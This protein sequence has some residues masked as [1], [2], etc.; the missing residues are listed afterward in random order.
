MFNPSLANGEQ[1][2][3]TIT[4]LCHIASHNDFGGV[5]VLDAVPLVAPT[6][7]AAIAM[8][9]WHETQDWY[10]QDRPQQNLR[11]IVAD[12]ERAGAVLIAWG[13]LAQR[14]SNWIGSVLEEIEC[15]LPDGRASTA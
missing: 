2:D 15:A 11:R 13:A 7:A 5:I 12:V 8:T 6:P 4:L 10:S 9:R 1:D 3:Q 14:C